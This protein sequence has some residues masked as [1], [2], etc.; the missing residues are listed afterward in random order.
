MHVSIAIAVVLHENEIPE[1][2]VPV[3]IAANTAGG[4]TTTYAFSLVDDD[5]GTGATGTRIAHL[6][7]VV[8]GGAGDDSLRR[9]ITLPKLAGLLIRPKLQSGI[10][11]VDGYPKSI[12]GQPQLF[13][14]EFPGQ[15][16]SLLFEVISEREVAQHLKKRVMAS[17]L[18]NVLEYGLYFG[19]TLE[20]TF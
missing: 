5:L 7:K 14:Q 20:N 13:H 4:L 17:R 8:L 2:Q 18:S 11:L 9:H 15:L 12:A 16:N 3:A 6:P 19:K 10:T 1:L